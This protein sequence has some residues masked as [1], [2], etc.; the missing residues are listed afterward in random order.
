[1]YRANFDYRYAH[2]L[3][4]ILAVNAF[5]DWGFQF[6]GHPSHRNQAGLL[7]AFLMDVL[8]HNRE[9]YPDVHSVTFRQVVEYVAS[10]GDLEHT[11][12]VGNCQD[13]RNPVK[14]KLD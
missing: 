14:P 13:S 11:L 10:E 1:M 4:P 12:K 6:Y 7:K 3:R 8:V 9:K 5:H 2:P